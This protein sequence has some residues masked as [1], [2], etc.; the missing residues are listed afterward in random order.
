[1]Q[2][3]NTASETSTTDTLKKFIQEISQFPLLTIEEEKR[4]AKAIHGKNVKKRNAALD[5][6][7][8]S[9]L[10]LVVKIAHDFKG[11]GLPLMDMI[12]DG[13][14]G[15][16][17]AAERFDTKHGAKFSSYAAWWIR[18]AICRGIAK[19]GRTIRI[20][21]QTQ[22]SLSL[23][24]RAISATTAQFKREPTVSELAA[25]TGFSIAKIN[26][27][28]ADKMVVVSL[29]DPITTGEE[30]ALEELVADPNAATPAEEMDENDKY[31]RLQ[32]CI[33]RLSQR[34]RDILHMRYMK[35][36]TLEEI[37][38]IIGRT[39][40]RVRQIQKAAQKKLRL[41]LENDPVAIPA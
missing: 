7:I 12:S 14:T 9:N 6:L 30:G 10:R 16:T 35:N 26:R 15:L 4:C 2:N 3:K 38:V 32:E 21:V 28:L 40:E 39:R 5:T 13:C 24:N 11:Y 33:S 18:Q 20:P 29:Q 25:E 23:L 8:N 34:E 27:L 22:R 36:M 37:S 31:I 17:K 1:M 41:M 19:S